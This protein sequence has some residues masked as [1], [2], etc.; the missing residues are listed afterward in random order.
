KV[1][2]VG[3]V[4][5]RI[6]MSDTHIEAYLS[7]IFSRFGDISSISLSKFGA[8][9]S[10]GAC[11]NSA[12]TAF[13]HINFAKKSSI[14][15]A[16][17]GAESDYALA[18]GE[19]CEQHGI[20][21]E[22]KSGAQIRGMF[23]FMDEDAEALQEESDL[24]ME[25][26]DEAETVMKRDRE[27]ALNTVDADGFEMVKHRSKRKRDD[28]N[29][30]KGE[31][32]RAGAARARGPRKKNDTE[33]KNFYRFQVREERMKDLSLLRRKFEEDKE[34][35]AKQKEARQFKPF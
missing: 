14:K 2:F 17:L 24:Y 5:Y 4:D 1:L 29:S 33:L 31:K 18:A 10:G 9:N 34:R 13:A 8:D 25:Q 27:A 22:R 23:A 20:R 11:E 21:F 32:R 3:N 7:L 28:G 16:L 6:N 12:D 26:F 35:V 30:Q 19:V 15:F